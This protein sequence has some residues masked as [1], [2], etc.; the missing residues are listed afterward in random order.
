MDDAPMMGVIQRTAELF[1]QLHAE[2]QGKRAFLL[3]FPFQRRP[4]DILHGDIFIA[5][6]IADIQ[7]S[8]DVAV[9]Q[10]H[11]GIGLLAERLDINGVV[12]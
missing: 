5:L 10:P 7:N 4:V 2:L 11:N 12:R 3:D 1:R 9:V 8:D 6:G